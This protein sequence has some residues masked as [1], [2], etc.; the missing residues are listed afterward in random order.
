MDSIELHALWRELVEHTCSSGYF[1]SASLPWYQEEKRPFLLP[2]SFSL[3]VLRSKMTS[4]LIN[5]YRKYDIARCIFMMWLFSFEV[6]KHNPRRHSAI[7]EGSA[8]STGGNGESRG[9]CMAWA[10]QS[11]ADAKL[12]RGEKTT[13]SDVF[14]GR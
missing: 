10:F 6:E 2:N 3:G 13:S 7:F 4:I 14:N 5:L 9:R 12:R 1:L 8:R 11:K